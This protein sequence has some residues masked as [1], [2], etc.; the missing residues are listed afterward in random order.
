MQIGVDLPTIEQLQ[1]EE[2][3]RIWL[4]EPEEVPAGKRRC[5]IRVISSSMADF[6]RELDKA[7]LKMR[8][9]LRVRGSLDTRTAEIVTASVIAKHGVPHSPENPG[10]VG[11][12]DG[13]NGEITGRPGDEIPYSV[14]NVR[15][16]LTKVPAVYA[17]VT[18][19]MDDTAQHQEAFLQEQ[20]KASGNGS[21]GMP[22]TAIPSTAET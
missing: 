12:Y 22:S 8:T 21:G 16:I 2:G 17:E 10:I 1:D 7:M 11:F 20:K 15:A 3:V 14:E 4:E 9:K 13:P 18:R 6:R 5:G 19:C